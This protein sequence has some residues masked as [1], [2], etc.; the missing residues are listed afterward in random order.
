MRSPNPRH[1][2]ES[3]A[4]RRKTPETNAERSLYVALHGSDAL[5]KVSPL[6]LWNANQDHDVLL[7]YPMLVYK[8]ESIRCI[9]EAFLLSSD[10]NFAIHQALSM[11]PEEISLYRELFFDTTVFR[12]AL[13]LM[14]FMQEIP[15]EHP[16]KAYYRIAYHQGLQALQWHFCRN[17]GDVLAQDVVKTIMT[18]S[19][20]RSME[21]RGQ[22]ITGKLAKEAAKYAKIS[23]EC[24][25]ALLGNNDFINEDAENLRIRFEE[26]RSNRTVEDLGLDKVVH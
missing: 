26:A 12:T 23:L 8:T 21:H 1:R 6:R 24:A 22:L 5:N 20:F 10:N 7:E 17:K 2:Y 9:L 15:E 18:D 14:V 13:E 19:Y 3:I 16:Y 11:P 4:S 25:R